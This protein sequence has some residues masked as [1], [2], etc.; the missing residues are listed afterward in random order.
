LNE[1]MQAVRPRQGFGADA[2]LLVA[3]VLL[4]GAVGVSLNAAPQLAGVIAAGSVALVLTYR[5]VLI[6]FGAALLLLMYSPETVPTLGPLSHPE[7]QKGIIFACLV[8]VAVARGIWPLR[9][10][11][12]AAYVLLAL[13]AVFHD[14]LTPGLTVTQ[15]VS[16]YITLT[17]GWL[18]LAVKW[19]REDEWLLRI[20]CL[21][22][23][24]CVV[25]GVLLQ[26][27][28]L[29]TVFQAA[30]AND[31][32][33]RLRGA[34]LA[35]VLGLMSFACCVA[36]AVY[37]RLSGWR[38]AAV[39][40]GV[41]VLILC[42]TASRGAAVALAVALLWPACRIAFGSLRT[43]PR[44]GVIRL[45]AVALILGGIAAV[46]VPRLEARNSG[47]RYYAGYGTVS[48]STS[49]RSEAWQEYWDIAQESPL[50]GHGLGSGPITKIQQ[51]GFTAQHNEFLRFFL[52]GGYVG[53]GLVLFTIVVAVALAIRAAP[54]RIRLDL[55]SAML[56]FVILSITDNT[57]TAI[58]MTVPI[59]LTLGIAANWER[60]AVPR[61]AAL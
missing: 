9:A 31:N 2:R 13:L 57:L 6:A 4:S 59:G 19:R 17:V 25:L 61:T 22:P 39:L 42:G 1:A 47:G 58:M 16:S 8:C 56:G 37:W 12:L 30:T 32:V 10:L 35:S 34:S 7:L 18:T 27:A 36:S 26:A 38:G 29:H 44:G 14:D 60:D 49:G 51:Q 53:G 24:L 5:A 21:L 46:V 15:M 55:V 28:G 48:D 23:L 54:Q 20:I 45:L 41:N 43:N 3:G 11:P 33:T 52:E 50:F 40:F